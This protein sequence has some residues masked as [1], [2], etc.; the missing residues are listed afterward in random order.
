MPTIKRDTRPIPFKDFF[1]KRCR[2][3]YFSYRIYGDS[4]EMRLHKSRRWIPW[5]E[6]IGEMMHQDN[7]ICIIISG[8]WFDEVADTII[9]I[10]QEYENKTG[11]TVLIEELKSHPEDWD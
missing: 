8:R 10:A 5:G 2:S 3:L 6:D 1:N 11:L 4:G 9:P 7:G